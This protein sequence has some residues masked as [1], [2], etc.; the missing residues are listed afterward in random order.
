[1]S[2]AELDRFHV[3]I[4]DE[5]NKIRTHVINIERMMRL[6]HADRHPVPRPVLDL[7]PTQPL[8]PAVRAA[9]DETP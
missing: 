4:M 9:I 1:M 7:S 3:T 8:D 2:E 5:L 6:L